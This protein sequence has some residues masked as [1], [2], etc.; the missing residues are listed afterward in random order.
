MLEQVKKKIAVICSSR[1]TYGYKRRIIDLIRKSD[2]LELQLIVTG[3]HLLKEYGYSVRDI[4]AD[5]FPISVRLAMA[6]ESDTPPAWAEALGNQMSNLSKVFERLKPDIVLVTGDRAEMFIA[7][8]TAAYMNIAVA[9][10]QAGD[11]SGHI[12]GVVRHAITKLAHLH[13]PACRDSAERVKKLGE[14]EWRIF[15]VGA[16]QLDDIVQGERMSKEELQNIFGFDFNK[17]VILVLFHPVLTEYEESGRQMEEIMGAVKKTGEQ[18]IVIFPNIDA[19]NYKIIEVAEKYATTP[20]IKIFRNINRQ[21]FISLMANAAV[22]VGNSSAGILEAPS[23]KLAAVNVGDRQ[24]GRLQADNVI[25]VGYS[26][27]EIF[28]AIKKALT[29]KNFK[30]RLRKCVNPYGDGHSSERIVKI[31]ENIKIDKKLLDKKITY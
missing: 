10:I 23:L 6:V 18:T 30:T 24:R 17:P 19:G 16:P 28:R 15:T 31:L 25:N 12:D 29:D 27:E 5:G 3:M 26:K 13:F 20:F 8:A 4:E 7:A 21:V 1:A 22:L 14:E 11:V 2:K 9:H